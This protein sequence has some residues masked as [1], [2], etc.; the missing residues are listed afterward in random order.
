MEPIRNLDQLIRDLKDQPSRR[1]AVAAGHDE[2]TIEAAA[3]AA[4]E[5][6]A[7]MILVGDAGRIVELCAAEGINPGLFTIVDEKD[8]VEAGRK[9]VGMVKGGE[10][11]VLMKGLIGT[12]DYMKLILDK[13]DGLLP[14]GN[15]LSHVSVFELPAYLE[16]QGKLIFGADVA[17][18]PAPDLETKVKILEYCIAAA[19]S[20]GIE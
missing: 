17:I 10:A 12:S 15:V 7:E 5:G 9:A 14:K 3:R 4:F 19:H 8:L 20:F 16:S 1:V 18:L 2:N 13:E 11:D 6:I